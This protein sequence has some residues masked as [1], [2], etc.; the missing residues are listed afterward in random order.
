[1]VRQ[2]LA[3]ARMSSACWAMESACWAVTSASMSAT[4]V[5]E[6]ELKLEGASGGGEQDETR[7]AGWC[8]ARGA[9]SGTAGAGGGAGGAL[10]EGSGRKLAGSSRRAMLAGGGRPLEGEAAAD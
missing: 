3:W 2:A 9:A 8:A 4:A 1:M 10:P 7:D 6:Q 5:S